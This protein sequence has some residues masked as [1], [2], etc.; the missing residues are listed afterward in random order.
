[1]VLVSGYLGIGKSAVVNALHEAIVPLRGLFVFGKCDQYKR[2]I[3]YAILAHVFQDLVRQLLV[4]RDEDLAR[5]RAAMLEALGASGRLVVDLVSELALLIGSQPP[6][7]EM[8]FREAENRF[9]T[10]LGGFLGVFAQRE[11]PLVL[12]L[13]DL[14]WLDAATLQFLMS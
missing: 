6:V 9:L 13:D 10:S 5:W 11:H 4:K 7:P 1:L 8:L 14:Q 3:L 2:D 12:F